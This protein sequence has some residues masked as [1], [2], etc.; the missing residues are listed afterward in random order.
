MNVLSVGVLVGGLLAVLSF[1]TGCAEEPGQ[2][3][4]PGA[5]V[6]ASSSAGEEVP[7]ECGATFSCVFH[8]PGYEGGPPSAYPSHVEPGA[9]V[10]DAASE[11]V[12][13][14]RFFENGRGELFGYEADWE[15]TASALVLCSGDGEYR[16]C[17]VC[18]PDEKTLPRQPGSAAVTG[19][20]GTPSSCSS[21]GGGECWHGCDRSWGSANT[22]SDDRCSGT[23]DS[24]ESLGDEDL[25]SS[26]PG[27][28]WRL[29]HRC[30][31][32]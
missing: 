6:G 9:C 13:D 30:P 22:A 1:A 18:T 29:P 16:S 15:R 26:I 24:C 19:C 4:A 8:S 31:L 11:A 10:L 17:Y 14:S 27:C 28:R 23:S 20:S 25:C 7:W 12:D 2:Q 32:A 3:A 21:R 5:S